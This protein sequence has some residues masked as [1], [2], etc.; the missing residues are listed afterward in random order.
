[1]ALKALLMKY[2]GEKNLFKI[3]FAA[4]TR[5]N[6]RWDFGGSLVQDGRLVTLGIP[7]VDRAFQM[8]V[9]GSFPQVNFSGGFGPAPKGQDEFNRLISDSSKA[10]VK[11][12]ANL[13][14]AHLTAR[15][16]ENP[17]LESAQTVDC[18]S[19]HTAQMVRYWTEAERTSL[20]NAN[21]GRYTSQRFNLANQSLD[22]S[23]TGNV[24]SF[25]FFSD[26][27]A[28]SQR[29]INE[30]ALVTDKLNEL[31]RRR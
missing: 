8:Y 16:L 13:E 15:R 18:A 19:C 11:E 4:T 17:T 28:I 10:Q 21:E 7:R 30:S 2:V 25:G 23:N 31:S 26:A 22:R 5:I 9:N 20:K 12:P 14:G 1:V 3:T 27:A 29:T 6:F 24:R